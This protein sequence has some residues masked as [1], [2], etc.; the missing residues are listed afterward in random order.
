MSELRF[1]ETG[2]TQRLKAFTG[3]LTAVHDDMT[4]KEAH[5]ALVGAMRKAFTTT[6]YAEIST[7]GLTPD[8]YRVTRVWNPDGSE[9]VTERSPWLAEG[10]PIREGG[11]IA[12]ILEQGEPVI[13]SELNIPDDDPVYS[14]LGQYRS[15]QATPGGMG[16][17]GNWV[18]VLSRETDEFD[19]TSLENLVVR[20]ALIGSALRNMQTLSELRDANSFINAEM[21]RIAS[22]QRA[23]LPS[24]T[25][26][27][28]GLDV[29][30]SWQTFDRA[31][32][33][34]YDFAEIPDG[35][36]G[37]LIADA[38]G[39]GPSAAVVAAMLNAIVHAYPARLD[40]TRPAPPLGEMLAFA[41]SQLAAKRIEQ[42]F[43]T[44]FVA[45]WDPAAMSFTYAR[46]GH[47]PPLLR[48]AAG[49]IVELK[50]VGGLP[51]AVLPDTVYGQASIE[52][53]SGDILL[54]YTDGIIDAVDENADPFGEERLKSA[55][56]DCSGS[57]R[58]ILTSLWDAVDLH[59]RHTRSGDD[60]TMVVLRVL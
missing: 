20:V 7:I 51:L 10:V 60:Q 13:V 11:V 16:L 31:G 25:P 33:D 12:K 45:Y 46:A 52:L 58:D 55:L 23:L 56:A 38:S 40:E 43:V 27:V 22:I 2:P 36:W 47:N 39:H 41:N 29:A 21:D 34:L 50:A 24:A 14:E 57:A 30:A 28:P 1:L 32:G 49:G 35:R 48:K 18:L 53:V 9:G 19:M 37:V 26:K 59:A 44:A 5:R 15:L 6:C 54:M 8:Q 42:S 17:A 4:M 3:I